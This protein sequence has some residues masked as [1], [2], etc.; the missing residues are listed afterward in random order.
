M[1]S[2]EN[3][4]VVLPRAIRMGLETEEKV[5]V[6]GELGKYFA[7][8][9]N[10]GDA[11]LGPGLGAQPGDVLA[12]EADPPFPRPEEPDDGL[13]EGGLSHSVPAE[14]AGDLTGPHVDAQPAQ[15]MALTV[16][17]MEILDLEHPGYPLPR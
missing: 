2:I 6:H 17:G 12:L 15:D 8:L 3:A 9:R 13:E 14:D 16:E 7:P 10:V 1:T 11:E 4:F 5:F